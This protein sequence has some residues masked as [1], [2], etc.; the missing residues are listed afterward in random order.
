M[1]TGQFSW[2]NFH[3]AST[4]DFQPCER[5][6]REPDFVS[7]SGSCYWNTPDGVV[8]ESDHWMA[9]IRSCN[10]YLAGASYRGPDRAGFC[11]YEDFCSDPRQC[12]AW[13][14]ERAAWERACDESDARQAAQEALRQPGRTIKA[15]R[16]VTERISSRKFQQIKERVE[17]TIAKITACYIVSTDGRRFGRHTLTNLEAA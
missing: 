11:R 10:W 13:N 3:D 17:L 12:E 7:G 4:A 5:P 16:T 8:R 14:I 1:A 9:G 2:D 6:A 15:I